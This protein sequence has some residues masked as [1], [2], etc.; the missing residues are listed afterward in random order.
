MVFTYLSQHHNDFYVIVQHTSPE[1]IDIIRRRV[2]C[3][4]I[5]VS[6][7]VGLK[8]GLRDWLQQINDVVFVL[9]WIV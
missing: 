7:L 1:R 2:L 5:V 3:D 8:I 6:C 4:D 9:N